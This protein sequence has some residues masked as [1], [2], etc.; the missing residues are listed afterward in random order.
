MINLR[1]SYR[2]IKSVS[3][4]VVFSSAMLIGLLCDIG[5]IQYDFSGNS[6]EITSATDHSHSKHDHGLGH[7]HSDDHDHGTSHDNGEEDCCKDMSTQLL[8]SL[9]ANEIQQPSFEAN[10]NFVAIICSIERAFLSRFEANQ[11]FHVFDG[12]PP[13]VGSYIRIIHQSFLI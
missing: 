4:M 3:L 9:I 13:R 12:P 7:E 6:H 10:Y 11:Y 8:S 2:R 1:S 5:Y